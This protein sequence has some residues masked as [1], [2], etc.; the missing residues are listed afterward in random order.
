MKKSVLPFALFII[1]ASFIVYIIFTR[2]MNDMNQ[3]QTIQT[4]TNVAQVDDERLRN[5]SAVSPY[6][7][8]ELYNTGEYV[9]IDV[10]TPGEIAE[11]K[12][13]QDALEINF[14][15]E[16]FR[17]KLNAL[18]KSQK[19]LVYCRSG[20]RSGQTIRI[21]NELGFE[22]VYDLEGG[23]NAWNALGYQTL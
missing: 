10:R 2:S 7:F 5:F 17:D 22:Q 18:D 16:D 23:M 13:V 8:T 6:M 19:Y 1:I 14:Y 20:S 3:E 15:D 4:G 11:G 9:V 12:I 21:M